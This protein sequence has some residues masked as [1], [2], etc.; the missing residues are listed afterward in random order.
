MLAFIIRI[1]R[2]AMTEHCESFENLSAHMPGSVSKYSKFLDQ[3]SFCGVFSNHTFAF[4]YARGLLPSRWFELNF[5]RKSANNM[6]LY[7]YS[8]SVG[9]VLF[10]KRI[11]T[12][13]HMLDQYFIYSNK[14]EEAKA[15]LSDHSRLTAIKNLIWA[16][17]DPPNFIGKIIKTTA[18]VPVRIDPQWIKK[19]LENILILGT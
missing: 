17:W 5:E 2:K 11:Y 8:G 6:K 3:P 13:D 7:F 18:A 16:G 19:T 9:R 12:G 14:P 1:N 4:T 15:F 10:M